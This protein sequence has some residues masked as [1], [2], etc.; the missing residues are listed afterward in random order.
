MRCAEKVERRILDEKLN[1]TPRAHVDGLTNR[2][3]PPALM[4]LWQTSDPGSYGRSVPD[5]QI[6][7]SVRVELER[8]LRWERKD[9]S[10]QH[11]HNLMEGFN[12]GTPR[13]RPITFMP[14]KVHYHQAGPIINGAI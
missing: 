2:P 9:K 14:I 3:L 4:K 5:P 10:R 13:D 12:M 6:Q 8:K 11:L 7:H 1:G